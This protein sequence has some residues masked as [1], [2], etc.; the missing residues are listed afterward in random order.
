MET[1]VEKPT[2]VT[3]IGVIMIIIGAFGILNAGQ[4]MFLPYMVDMQRQ[5]MHEI[6]K[7]P[8]AP[9]QQNVQTGQPESQQERVNR[10]QAERNQK[11]FEAIFS[12]ITDSIE[13]M[14]KLP[15]WYKDWASTFGIIS[16]LVSAFYLFAGI[17]MLTMK[18]YALRVL[19]FSL[20]VS[21][22][23]AAS[24]IAIYSRQEEGVLKL[25]IP[26]LIGIVAL[27]AVLGTVAV[28]N[29]KD[30]PNQPKTRV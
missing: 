11:Q 20:C 24:Q 14:L 27:D 15:D 13:K 1:S 10:E 26:S 16:I 22:L 8:L 21:A 2:W 23:W 3:V 4:K 9:L 25:F 12:Q 18:P 19:Y 17:I 7:M 5:I 30:L 6:G 28:L 29:A